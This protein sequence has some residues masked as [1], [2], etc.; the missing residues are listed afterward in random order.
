MLIPRAPGLGLFMEEP[1]FKSYNRQFDKKGAAT[2]LKENLDSSEERNDGSRKILFDDCEKEIE[3]F[4]RRQIYH[5]I[6]GIDN[7]EGVFM[8]WIRL[9]DNYLF[10]FPFFEEKN[11]VIS[12]ELRSKVF[13]LMNNN[14]SSIRT[15]LGI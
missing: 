15:K 4:K 13:R 11:A 6:V 7:A 3:D 14:D 8:E 1:V 12:P 9:I 5:E 10:L 2:E